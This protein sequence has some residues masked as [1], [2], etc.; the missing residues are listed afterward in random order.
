MVNGFKLLYS[1]GIVNEVPR[2]IGLKNVN[3]LDVL[4]RLIADLKSPGGI[5]Y[6]CF[7]LL[8]E[9]KMNVL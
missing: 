3:I 6:T 7:I 5:G 1:S 8:A 2:F 4:Q 9:D